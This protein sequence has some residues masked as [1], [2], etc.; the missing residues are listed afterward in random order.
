M[1]RKETKKRKRVFMWKKR[2]TIYTVLFS[3]VLLSSIFSPV[4]AHDE[5]PRMENENELISNGEENE[6]NHLETNERENKNIGKTNVEVI[7]GKNIAIVYTFAELKTA[8]SENNGIDTVYLG[9][10]IE[11]AG[12]IIVHSSKKNIVIDGTY[13]TVRSRLTEY[14]STSSTTMICINHAGFEKIILRNI[15]II[16]RNYHGLIHVASNYSSDVVLWYENVDYNGPQI[17]YSQ[18][19]TAVYKDTTIIIQSN[20]ICPIGK[21]ADVSRVEFYGVVTITGGEAPDSGAFTYIRDGEMI[22]HEDSYVSF[23]SLKQA[24]LGGRGV[25]ITF[26]ENATLNYSDETSNYGF[27][28]EKQLQ[29]LTLYENASMN[30]DFTHPNG[31]VNQVFVVQKDV[32]IG[33]NAELNVIANR[34][35]NFML[36]QGE[37]TDWI[38]DGGKISITG[39]EYLESIMKVNTLH[40]KNSG[41]LNIDIEASVHKAIFVNL[42]TIEQGSSV[43]IHIDEITYSGIVFENTSM[44]YSL[45]NRGRF[46][47]VTGNI[48]SSALSVVEAWNIIYIRE[49]AEFRIECHNGDPRNSLLYFSSNYS[50]AYLDVYRPKSVVLYGTGARLISYVRVSPYNPMYLTAEQINYWET[51]IPYPQIG[52]FGKKPNQHWIKTNQEDFYITGLLRN[53]STSVDELHNIQSNW[54]SEDIGSDPNGNFSITKARVIAMGYL[55]VNMD[56]FTE[57]STVI[58][59]KT[60]PYTSI[61]LRYTLENATEYITL[62]ADE[63]GNFSYPVG[64]KERGTTIYLEFSNDFFFA[65]RKIHIGEENVARACTFEELEGT[66]TGDNGI[67]TILLCGDIT[68]QSNIFIPSTKNRITIDGASKENRYTLTAETSNAGF[69]LANDGFEDFTLQNLNVDSRNI[70]GIINITLDVYSEDVNIMF[71]NVDFR[72]PLAANVIYGA[73]IFK[74]STITITD[75]META[76]KQ[77]SSASKVEFYGIVNI[78]AETDTNPLFNYIIRGQMILHE[79]AIVTISEAMSALFEGNGT[80]LILLNNSVLN[81]YSISAS[82]NF[83]DQISLKTLTLREEAKLNVSFINETENRV[84]TQAFRVLETVRMSNGSE[85][86]IANHRLS[87]NIVF[88]DSEWIIDGGKIFITGDRPTNAI[89]RISK[90]LTLLNGGELIIDYDEADFGLSIDQMIIEKDSMVDININTINKTLLNLGNEITQ[91]INSYSLVVEG[92]FKATV[93]NISENADGF[94]VAMNSIYVRKDATFQLAYFSGLL[95]TALITKFSNAGIES[96]FYFEEPK[97]VL[98]YSPNARL[99]AYRNTG[100]LYLRAKQINYSAR[101]LDYPEEGVF[102]ELMDEQWSKDNKDS[103]YISSTLKAG[104]DAEADLTDVISNWQVHDRSGSDPSETFSSHQGRILSM[105]YINVTLPIYYEDSTILEGRTEPYTN[106]EIYLYTPDATESIQLVADKNGDFSYPLGILE[107]GSNIYLEFSKDFLY[108]TRHLVVA[109]I[110]SLKI[111][112]IPV[113]EFEP[114]EVSSNLNKIALRQDGNWAI[115]ITDTRVI[116]TNWKLYAK[117]IEYPSTIKNNIRYELE[118]SLI[119]VDEAGNRTFLSTEYET[120]IYYHNV[121][122]EGAIIQWEEDRGILFEYVPSNVFKDSVYQAVIEWTLID[123]P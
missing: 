68:L 41:Q 46:T 32:Y 24:F 103:I 34:R 66:I 3:I 35:V 102:G 87:T 6:N 122:E 63:N 101:T 69:I 43:D 123:A 40:L 85:L 37:G 115:T 9:A 27:S 22:F 90:S 2:L 121:D 95:R 54:T 71:D 75:S 48:S 18:Y 5:N 88:G 38:V 25:D 93:N 120:L 28:K 10:D 117:I 29:S 109:D 76:I 110:G 23:S 13:N 8:L 57:D 36:I 11:M 104:L 7:P 94:L 106:I 47:F 19:A 86:N 84:R 30:L 59:G 89:M 72:G 26:E 15:D 53:G 42:V 73:V 17:T 108:E 56:A 83:S 105:G 81:Y 74:D 62:T 77:V 45:D 79:D 31:S 67:D 61:R 4:L 96:A 49:D 111:I 78:D 118:D 70:A 113:L 119:F 80:D 50:K 114:G 116:K 99:F 21:V 60:E 65:T 51:R 92:T 64:K 52:E 112:E 98:L 39:N 20:G 16:G 1:E 55:T 100:T 107:E 97:S 82:Q 14:N 12:Q 91:E 44:E 58:S 33:K